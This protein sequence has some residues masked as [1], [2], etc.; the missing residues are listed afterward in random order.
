MVIVCSPPEVKG[1]LRIH[2]CPKI[3]CKPIEWALSELFRTNITLSWLEQPIAPTTFST[4]IKWTGQFGLCSRL[5]STLS[6]WPKIRLEALQ[7][8]Y[9]D[10]PAERYALTPNLG[11]FRAEINSLGETIITENR[12]KAALERCRLENEPFEVEL[13]FL[14]GTPWD[15]DLEPFRKSYVNSN[16]KWIS[17]IS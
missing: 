9:K 11:I 13:A 1:E 8:N 3:I 4:E 16:L 6:H 2:S 7:E 17:K 12:L 14:L 15:E 5:V 10:Y